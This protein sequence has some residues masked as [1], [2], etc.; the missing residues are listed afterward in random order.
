MSRLKYPIPRMARIKRLT[1]LALDGA[2][3]RYW[4]DD[5]NYQ[6]KYASEYL[7]CK[8]QDLADLLA[9]FSPRVSVLRSAKWA[10]RYLNEKSF[11]P[12]CTISH[13][14]AIAH[15]ELTGEIRGSK[16]GPFA[17]ALMGDRDALVL[18][19]WMAKALGVDSKRFEIKAVWNR[20]AEKIRLVAQLLGWPVAETQA[21]IWTAIVRENRVNIPRFD[22]RALLASEIPV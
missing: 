15:W 4:Y 10:L 13:K 14:F 7:G 2:D 19:T 1:Q 18:D 3:G 6:I 20:A 5:A 12:D 17:R 11:A 22:M 8:V 9:L 21:A 16:T